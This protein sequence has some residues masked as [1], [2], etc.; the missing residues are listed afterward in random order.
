MYAGS[1]Q[2]ANPGAGTAPSI[3]VPDPLNPHA[4]KV[5]KALS[6]QSAWLKERIAREFALKKKVT[7]DE[8]TRAWT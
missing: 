4:N 5:L 2:P 7:H 3:S 1:P 8:R 6:L